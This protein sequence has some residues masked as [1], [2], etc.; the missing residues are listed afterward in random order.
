MGVDPQSR[1]HIFDRIEQLR[2]EQRTIIYTTHYMEEAQRLCDRVGIMDSGRILAIDRVEALI[3]QH[4]GQSFVDAELL[5]IPTDASVL[6]AMPD[7]NQR[8][9]FSSDT[10]LQQ[11]V[12]LTEAGVKLSELQIRRPDLE[13]VFLNLTGRS[14]RVA[15]GR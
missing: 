14:L 13:C 12:Q 6:P 2:A 1:N 4:G 7:E 8:L 3:R 11:V 9:R 10:P 15:R 5:E